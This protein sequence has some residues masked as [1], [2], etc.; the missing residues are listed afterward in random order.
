MSQEIINRV[1]KS[2]LKTIDLDFFCPYSGEIPYAAHQPEFVLQPPKSGFNTVQVRT[3]CF[4]R[5]A[6][7]ATQGR[8]FFDF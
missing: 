7:G 8:N 2:K 1:A 5:Q 6:H 4:S 3:H